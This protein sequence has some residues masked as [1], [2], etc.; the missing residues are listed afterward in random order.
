MIQENK[1]KIAMSNLFIQLKFQTKI[2]HVFEW[3]KVHNLKKSSLWVNLTISVFTSLSDITTQ[4]IETRNPIKKVFNVRLS[5]EWLNLPY[6]IVLESIFWICFL[7]FLLLL[8][9]LSIYIFS[10]M[11]ITKIHEIERSMQTI[12]DNE[13]TIWN[14]NIN[15]K[16]NRNVIL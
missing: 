10:L 1:Q 12:L 6:K 8:L 9:L 4:S 5:D 11:A 2:V 16:L 3:K 15:K 13:I 7:S 14:N